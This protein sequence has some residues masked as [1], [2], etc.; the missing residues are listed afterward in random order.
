MLIII[1]IIGLTIFYYIISSIGSKSNSKPTYTSSNPSTQ[2]SQSSWLPKTTAPPKKV[3]KSKNKLPDNIVITEEFEL[4]FELMENTIKSAYITGKAG[5]GKSTLLT[6]FRQ[7][8]KKNVIVLAPTGIAAINVEGSTIHS[9]FRF[10]P[11]LLK[12]QIFK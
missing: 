5:T 6:Y 1:G 9:F 2:R 8:T 10:A 11:N 4:A 7:K 3:Y 12:K